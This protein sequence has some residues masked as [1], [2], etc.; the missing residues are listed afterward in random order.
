[1]DHIEALVSKLDEVGVALNEVETGIRVRAP[2]TI[3]YAD[4]ATA[5]YPGF[6]TD[7]QAQFM[8]LMSIADGSSMIIENIFENRFMHVAEL[9]RMGAKIR[10]EGNTAFV[11]GVPKL[12]GAP[13]MAS[14][15]RASAALVLAGLAADGITEIHRIYHLDRGY[16]RIEKKLRTLG[17]KIKRTQVKF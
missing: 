14:D 5:P 13:V 15:L 9:N 7:F 8:A 10:I 2:E 11:T 3:H 17:A 6:A 16:D 12:S 4:V 1:M